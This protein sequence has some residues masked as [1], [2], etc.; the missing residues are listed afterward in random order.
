M[1]MAEHLTASVS[2]VTSIKLMSPMKMAAPFGFL[3]SSIDYVQQYYC[4][5][6]AFQY[7]HIWN[8][9]VLTI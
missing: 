9:Q 7:H 1:L 6:T 5:S 4:T 2:L 8:F 3:Y